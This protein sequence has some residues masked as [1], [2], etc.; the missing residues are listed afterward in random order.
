MELMM[1]NIIM[2]FSCP[3]LAMPTF[4]RKLPIIYISDLTI[5]D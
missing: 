3:L 5:I 4:Q 1:Y 2:L